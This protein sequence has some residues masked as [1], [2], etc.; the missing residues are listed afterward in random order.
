MAND[1]LRKFRGCPRL[2]PQRT[3]E[4]VGWIST[5]SPIEIA[6]EA[7]GIVK[8]TFYR[9]YRWGKALHLGE[10]STDM[11]HFAP[12]QPDE[13]DEAFCDRK[14]RYDWD[15][16]L[17]EDLFLTVMQAVGLKRAMW[18][19]RMD[20][21]AME[22]KE[23]YANAWVLERSVPELFA[24]VTTNRKEIE[25]KVEVNHTSEVEAFAQLF[26]LL[27]HGRQQALP[28]GQQTINLPEGDA[29]AADAHHD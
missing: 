17:L 6:C 4:I 15:C 13:T 25:A 1:Y 12:R 20:Q 18:M 23:M 16:A 19:R 24:L 22:D 10:S 7:T 5:G 27:G 2:T 11:L 3:A 28:A 29:T 26:A 8:D 14:Y 9:W 21:R